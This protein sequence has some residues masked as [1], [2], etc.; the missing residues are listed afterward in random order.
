MENKFMVK[1]CKKSLAR[2][3]KYYM[4]Q[5]DFNREEAL[6]L[7]LEQTELRLFMVK[8]ELNILD[9]DKTLSDENPFA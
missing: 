2:D 9:K 4:E 5:Y 8:Q 1:Q 7:I 6:R 3:L